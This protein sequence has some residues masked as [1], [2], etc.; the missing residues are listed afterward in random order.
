MI[1]PQNE[2]SQQSFGL[3]KDNQEHLFENVNLYN[4]SQKQQEIA[5][6][7]IKV[8]CGD[9]RQLYEGAQQILS[10]PVE[11]PSNYIQQSLYI[12]SA[13][14]GFATQNYLNVFPCHWFICIGES[15]SGKSLAN[16]IIEKTL[17]NIKNNKC[18]HMAMPASRQGL[19]SKFNQTK[20]G[21]VPNPNVF[22][23]FDEGLNALLTQLW[24]LNGIECTGPL[25]PLIETLLK[26]YGPCSHMPEINNKDPNQ[27]C[28]RVDFPRI[29]LTANGQ[30]FQLA[31]SSRFLE[32]GFY[33][34][35]FVYDFVGK[36]VPQD[37]VSFLDDV[38]NTVKNSDLSIGEEYLKS[39]NSKL[40]YKLPQNEPVHKFV[41]SG[42]LPNPS[43]HDFHE[44]YHELMEYLNTNNYEYHA[45]AIAEQYKNRCKERFHAYAWLHAWGCDRKKPIGQDTAV[46]SLFLSLHYQNILNRMKNLPKANLHDYDLI[47]YIYQAIKKKPDIKRMYI[48]NKISKNQS[49]SKFDGRSI[50]RAIGYLVSEN[51]I[52]QNKR[53]GF[54]TS[55]RV[56]THD[57]KLL[58]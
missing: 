44:D 17:Y 32:K 22:I 36:V 25:G 20:E 49:L 29:G 57:P 16:V 54:P 38:E 52:V 33:H 4:Y 40:F 53:A 35:C 14:M 7:L 41:Q 34:R 13:I 24:P 18:W 15:G 23:D 21:S 8:L 39:F 19:Y 50:D 45:R 30:N 47:K 12:A 6:D 51:Y 2:P 58:D 9:W 55:Y 27:S 11:R 42:R 3:Q 26:T 37:M 46:A 31:Y 10:G 48:T 56:S 28:K 43:G 5:V 1:I